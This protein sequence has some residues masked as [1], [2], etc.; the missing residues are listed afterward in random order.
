MNFMQEFPTLTCS[1]DGST[2]IYYSIENFNP[3]DSFKWVSID[4]VTGVLNINA[5]AEVKVADYSFSIKSTIVEK[6]TSNLKPITLKV[7]KW[8]VDK[9]QK[10]SNS[11]TTIA[12]SECALGYILSKS[13]WVLPKP[14]EVSDSAKAMTITSQS[15][16]GSTTVVVGGVSL[17]N[18]SSLSSLW[19]MVNQ[20]QLLFLFYFYYIF[21]RIIF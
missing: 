10:C 18:T 15:V 4:P 14:P 3:Y 12:C 13:E 9:C 20:I 17:A 21:F 8:T 2:T 11:T 5:S 7:L 6:S 16:T 1:K 19:S